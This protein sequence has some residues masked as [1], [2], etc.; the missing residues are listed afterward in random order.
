MPKFCQNLWVWFYVC[1]CRFHLFYVG[2]HDLKDL[3]CFKCRSWQED[4]RNRHM[5]CFDTDHVG[6]LI[7]AEVLDFSCLFN[8]R[9]PHNWKGKPWIWLSSSQLAVCFQQTC[10]GEVVLLNAHFP[11]GDYIGYDMLLRCVLIDAVCVLWDGY[12][13]STFLVHGPIPCLKWKQPPGLRENSLNTGKLVSKKNLVNKSAALKPSNLASANI[14]HFEISVQQHVEGKCD[15]LARIVDS[16]VKVKLL[17]SEDQSVGQTESEI[18]R[19]A[20][21]TYNLSTLQVSQT[22]F[23]HW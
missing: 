6:V 5:A 15:I 19:Q 1:C 10:V 18:K 21:Q 20:K 4:D 9:V 11:A 8:P 7:I 13:I 16:N 23:T 14:R 22:K 17:F 12:N 3:W 2:S